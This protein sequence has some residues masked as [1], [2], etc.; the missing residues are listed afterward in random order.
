MSWDTA[1]ACAPPQAE[2]V[3]MIGDGSDGQDYWQKTVQHD[4]R[5]S[6]VAVVAQ[7]GI[8]HCEAAL[9]RLNAPERLSP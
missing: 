2:P 1:V 4:R 7:E 5:L 6:Q 9:S 3:V 8:S